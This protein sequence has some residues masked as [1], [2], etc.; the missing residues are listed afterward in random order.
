LS[1]SPIA[2][3]ARLSVELQ[4]S[5]PL[6]AV[7]SAAALHFDGVRAASS[8]LEDAPD[9]AEEAP[10][11]SDVLGLAT[12]MTGSFAGSATETTDAFSTVWR[13]RRSAIVDGPDPNDGVPSYV[14]E[15][16]RRATALGLSL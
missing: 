14:G 5:S 3:R 4:P 11:S 10:N 12:F 9:P 16:G 6:D 2:S 7:D 1:P 8:P 15:S 13:G